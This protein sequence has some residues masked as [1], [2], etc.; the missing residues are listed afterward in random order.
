MTSIRLNGTGHELGGDARLSALVAALTGRAV[1]A[2]GHPADG[3]RLG[4]AVALNGG[5][6]PRSQ[7][8]GT[9]LQANDDVE[10]VTAVQGG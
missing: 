7:W 2:A 6:V 1:T 5:I 10:I 4:V 9:E 8:Q 3:G